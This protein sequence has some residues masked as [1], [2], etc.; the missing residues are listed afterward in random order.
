MQ[1]L[2]DDMPCEVNA[3]T[4]GE[5]LDA[6][7][8]LAEQRGRL[9]VDVSV[10]GTRWTESDLSSP[11]R[12][13]AA[14]EIVHFTSAAPRELVRQTFADAADALTDADDL[15]RETAQLLQ[16]DRRTVSLDKLNA[17]IS[18]WLQVQEAI[19]KGSQLAGLDLDTVALP[20]PIGESINA[21]NQRLEA[22]HGA[23]ARDDVIALADTLLYEFPE[24]VEEWRRILNELQCLLEKKNH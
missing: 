21:L 4:V 16:A 10:D 8:A 19:V 15:Q 20:R 22:V 1:V 7:S 23:L 17:A 3:T 2:L 24:V 11:D 12:T 6:A 9:I 14:A 18:I 5:A 13:D